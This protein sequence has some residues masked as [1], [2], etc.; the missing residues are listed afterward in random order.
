MRSLD[1]AS[2]KKRNLVAV[3]VA[4]I[5]GRQNDDPVNDAQHDDDRADDDARQ[6]QATAVLSGLLDL[7]K[8]DHAQDDADD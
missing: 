5:T 2:K 4:P 8:C 6:C 1:P 7:V 3:V